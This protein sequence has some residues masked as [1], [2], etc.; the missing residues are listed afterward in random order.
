MTASDDDSKPVMRLWDLRK[1]TTHPMLELGGNN[2]AQS[3]GVAGHSRGIVSLNWCPYDE[4]IIVSSS[5]DKRT[6][7]WD[8]YSCQV[9]EELDTT[10]GSSSSGGGGGSSGGGSGGL[11]GGASS[12]AFGS[13]KFFLAVVFLCVFLDFY[14]FLPCK[15]LTVLFVLCF[16]ILQVEV[17][18]EMCLVRVRLLHL[19]VVL[20]LVSEVKLLLVLV[21]RHPVVVRV[22]V[23]VVVHR[24]PAYVTLCGVHPCPVCWRVP[25][26]G[27]NCKFMGLRRSGKK[28]N[29][30]N[31]N[32]NN[33]GQFL[34]ELCLILYFSF[35]P[36]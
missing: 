14:F 3:G 12:N 20:L 7:F 27:E 31:N 6:L 35:L 30:N 2:A 23:V 29:N 13:G 22:L 24:I 4:A 28:N 10:G 18:V 32:N 16:C 11:G 5:K 19:V 34:E 25:R 21:H 26:W 17:V 1:S 36:F 33:C 15:Q 8:L 9:V